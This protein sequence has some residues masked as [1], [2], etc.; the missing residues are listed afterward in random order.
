MNEQ[1]PSEI[2]SLIDYFVA[3]K[4]GGEYNPMPL[5]VAREFVGLQAK[6]TAVGANQSR[7]SP[8]DERRLVELR[9]TYDRT[10]AVA[11][12]SD[13]DSARFRH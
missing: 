9:K 11:A 2:E 12:D 6:L 4:K 8:E 10:T 13:S 1:Q 7:L 5:D 3:G